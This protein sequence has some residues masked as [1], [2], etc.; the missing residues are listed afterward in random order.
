M[1]FCLFP[2]LFM[3]PGRQWLCS[4]Y[5]FL[6]SA[7]QMF[8]YT[9]E[10][11]A[12]I[13]LLWIM[14]KLHPEIGKIICIYLRK[15]FLVLLWVSLCFDYVVNMIFMKWFFPPSLLFS[16]PFFFS[17]SVS[18]LTHSLTDLERSWQLF[19]WNKLKDWSLTKQTEDN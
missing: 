15:T 1:M 3:D 14:V 6:P 11:I 9:K 18:L 19:T 7:S 5:V 13:V 16:L 17:L 2:V 12:F 4:L 8:I 10:K